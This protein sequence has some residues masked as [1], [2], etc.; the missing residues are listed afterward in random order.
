MNRRQKRSWALVLWGVFILTLAGLAVFL[1]SGCAKQQPV[2]A[3]EAV[4]I[5]KSGAECQ[6][7]AL[8]IAST[9]PT[10]QGAKNA[11]AGLLQTSPE[12]MEIFSGNS[13]FEVHCPGDPL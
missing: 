4:H 6:V 12:C 13:G 11:L 5:V 7:L 1:L 8:V 10:C 3:P 9:T 2:K